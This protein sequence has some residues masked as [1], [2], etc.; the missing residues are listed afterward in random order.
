[1][2]LDDMMV[3]KRDEEKR[4]REEREREEIDTRWNKDMREIRGELDKREK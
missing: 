1:M 3:K 2:T 4:I